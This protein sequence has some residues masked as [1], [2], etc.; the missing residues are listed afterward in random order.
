MIKLIFDLE[1]MM[2]ITLSSNIIDQFLCDAENYILKIKNKL[3]RPDLFGRWYN[4]K[5][6]FVK[7]YCAK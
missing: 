4:G 7:R 6:S 3:K 5:E 2:K 1:T